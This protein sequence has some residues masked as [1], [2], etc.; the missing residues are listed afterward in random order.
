M[1][2]PQKVAAKGVSL[3]PEPAVSDFID[4]LGADSDSEG[5]PLSAVD[6]FSPTQFTGQPHQGPKDEPSETPA[7]GTPG[8]ASA[9]IK[10]EITDAGGSLAEAAAGTPT[11]AGA[12]VKRGRSFGSSGGS[13]E[14]KFARA[15]NKD[16]I[17]CGGCSRIRG[18]SPCFLVPGEGC[19][20]PRND[21]RGL[22]CRDCSN[23]YRTNFE[24]G[25]GLQQFSRWLKEAPQNRQLWERTLLAH[26]SLVWEGESKIT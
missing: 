15:S 26:L 24:T 13:P 5:G 17:E 19:A 1:A 21:G 9:S 18:V 6:A 8:L 4:L 10:T 7:E 3:S 11:T 25:K 16:P 22:W 14:A 2:Q 20:W 23:C 12:Q